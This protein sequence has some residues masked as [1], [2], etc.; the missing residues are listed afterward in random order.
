LGKPGKTVFAIA[1]VV[2]IGLYV[3]VG[4]GDYLVPSKSS[5]YSSLSDAELNAL[6]V[7]WEY[8]DMLRNIEN[9]KGKVVR[10]QG[11][12]LTVE[13]AGG[14]RYGLSVS[15]GGDTIIVDYTGKRI[16]SGDRV[17]V[18]GEV[19]HVAELKSLLADMKFPYPFVKAIRVN[20]LSC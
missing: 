1:L 10:F 15:T 16:L 3:V 6:A 17:I 14:D 11:N 20:C 12:V 8:D 9:Y 13:H 7:N 5:Q 4:F 18:Y 2:G 19:T